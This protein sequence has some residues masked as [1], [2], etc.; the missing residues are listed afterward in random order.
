MITFTLRE[1][2]LLVFTLGILIKQVTLKLS[3]WAQA[4]K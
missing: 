2:I 3:L 4:K 1:A